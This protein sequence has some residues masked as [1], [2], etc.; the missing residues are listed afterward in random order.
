MKKKRGIG[1]K[2]KLSNRWFYTLI[3]FG[4]LAIAGIG[5]Y[6][7]TGNVGHPSS[8]IDET[9]PTVL[10]SVKDGV[11]WSELS[12]IPSG[13]ADG[14]DDTGGASCSASLTNCQD[15]TQ[16]GEDCSNCFTCPSG[17]VL[18]R[19]YYQNPCV[20]FR[21]GCYKYTCCSISISCN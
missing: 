14:V 6:A 16:D 10:T 9:D 13:F 12:G 8:Q 19:T 15:V 3:I 17:K 7:Y 21:Y 20:G 1:I 4:I 5:V 18:R 11:S 2:I